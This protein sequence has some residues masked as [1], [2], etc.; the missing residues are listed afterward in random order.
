MRTTIAVLIAVSIPAAAAAQRAQQGGDIDL[1]TFRPAMDSRGYI[2]LNA[3][4]VLG[5][6]QLSFGLVTNWGRDVLSFERDGDTYEVNNILTPTLVGA[7]GLKLGAIELELGVSI[8]FTLVSGDRGPDDDGGTP[9]EP[10]DDRNF[11]FEGQGL[12]DVGLHAKWRLLNTSKGARIGVALVGSVFL[13]TASE[14]RAWLGEQSAAPQATV[15][16]DREWA[17]GDV[18]TTANA[19]VRVRSANAV[20]TDDAAMRLGDMRMPVTNETIEV[21]STLPFGA[22]V[23]Y[24]VSRQR[25]DVVAEVFGQVPL[26]GENYFPLEAVAGIKVYL[27][28][29]SFLT[30]GGGLG[31][32]G[33]SGNPDARAFLGIVFE[34]NIG[35]RDGDGIKDDVDRCPDDP[36]DFDDFEDE[37]GCPELDND[38]DQ[39]LDVDDRCPNVPEDRDGDEDDDG[40]PET[41][42]ADRDGDRIVDEL[43]DCPDDPEDIDDFEDEDGCPDPDNDEDGI[44]DV[45]DLCPNDPEDFDDWEDEEGCPDPDN[46]RDRI[47]DTDDACKNEPENYNGVEDDDGCPDRDIV[48]EVDDELMILDKIHFEYNKAVI[49]EESFPILDAV[50]FTIEHNPALL[51]VEVQG[52]T[53]ERGSDAYNLELSQRRADAVVDYL[54]AYGIARKRLVGRGYGETEPI[55]DAHNEQAWANNR[56]VQFIIRKRADS[57]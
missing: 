40:C 51:R 8:P 11:K 17:G 24:A 45:V 26:G 27:A 42:G 9:P 49:K 47:L 7:Y 55:D 10:N 36:E 56:R 57:D 3:S 32:I 14:E 16:V 43:D 13:P 21:G 2:T 28:R 23:A 6:Q 50:G 20:F 52:H 15:V 39:I 19:G 29:N 25:F 1:Q 38:R 37:D 53:D 34:P 41:G 22:G 12:G 35:D 48:T 33:A 4:Q 18:R 30:L 5:H 44:L 54:E 31:L 46:D